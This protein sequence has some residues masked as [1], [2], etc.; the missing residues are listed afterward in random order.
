MITWGGLKDLPDLDEILPALEK[1]PDGIE[2]PD[3]TPPEDE[4]YEK[5]IQLLETAE[6]KKLRK[7]VWDEFND[8]LWKA[9]SRDGRC[10]I[11]LYS[12]T[13]PKGKGENWLRGIDPTT[14][15]VLWKYDEP[16]SFMMMDTEFAKKSDFFV[17]MG[18]LYSRE[19]R[20]KLFSCRQG[21]L[22]EIYSAKGDFPPHRMAKIAPDEKSIL[23]RNNTGNILNIDL[24][25]KTLWEKQVSPYYS[26]LAPLYISY[27]G[28]YLATTYYALKST[29]FEEWDKLKSSG[30]D[31]NLII[32]KE[33]EDYRSAGSPH[34]IQLIEL[35][36]GDTRLKKRYSSV[37]GDRSTKVLMS[38]QIFRIF[39]DD[40]VC[41]S[42]YNHQEFLD[43]IKSSGSV[44]ALFSKQESFAFHV[45][46]AAIN[47]SKD[48]RYL[49][50]NKKYYDLQLLF[51]K[52][53]GSDVNQ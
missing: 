22:R 30:E 28:L 5:I 44:I 52:M 53:K 8:G 40:T 13:P 27:D 12:S 4:K 38:N 11:E 49:Y 21:F 29:P 36:T 23:V 20:V 43:K 50:A 47:F 24:S 46:P 16:G 14:F 48:E 45:E 31:I 6:R 10:V 9:Q 34:E 18:L 2:F 41:V 17:L 33:H 51:R 19:T 32:R 1:I 39:K 35:K 15:E 7:K 3:L 37:F 25:G 42:A 26:P